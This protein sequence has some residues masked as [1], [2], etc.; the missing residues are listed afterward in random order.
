MQ[1][2]FQV[3]VMGDAQFLPKEKPMKSL[4]NHHRIVS[5]RYS[6]EEKEV[7]CDSYSFLSEKFHD[8]MAYLAM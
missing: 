6:D 8:M 5:I 7:W 2:H 1:I 3:W 4:Q